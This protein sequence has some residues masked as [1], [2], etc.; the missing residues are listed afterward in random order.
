MLFGRKNKQLQVDIGDLQEERERL[1]SFLQ[2]NLKVNILS[3]QNRLAVESQTI[4][5]QELQRLVTKF[6]YRRNL[7]STHW[8][9]LDGDTVRI[10][11]FK[12]TSKNPKKEKKGVGHQTAAQSWG[13]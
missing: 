8:A 3:I 6:V 7:N 11:R 4:P 2:Q 12:G 5:P 13:L 9:S 1:L 10:N